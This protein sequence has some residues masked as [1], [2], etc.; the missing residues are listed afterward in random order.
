ME[1]TTGVKEGEKR[2]TNIAE[3]NE[4]MHEI[5]EGEELKDKDIEKRLEDKN[6]PPT[7]KEE[8]KKLLVKIL[9]EDENMREVTAKE[10]AELIIEDNKTLDEA[11]K[12]LNEKEYEG[13]C[14]GTRRH[15]GRCRFKKLFKT[16]F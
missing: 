8:L 12:I 3:V 2:G 4:E 13:D 10:V 14:F 11:K 6:P 16:A 7:S 1:K 15:G 5:E 9:V